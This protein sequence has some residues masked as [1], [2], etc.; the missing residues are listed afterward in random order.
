[1]NSGVF[2][3]DVK[4]FM[5]PVRWWLIGILLLLPFQ[6]RAADFFAQWNTAISALMRYLDEITVALFFPLALALLYK[7]RANQR[8]L[9][10]IMTAII[11]VG[12]SGIISG[13]IN[14]NPLFITTLGIFDYIKNFLVIVIYAVFFRD[15]EDFKSVFQMVLAVALF[16]GAVAFLQELWALSS[17]YILGKDIFDMSIYILRP[18]E[19]KMW[20]LDF[21]R[22]GL[23]RAP[24]LTIHPNNFGLYCLLILTIY[25]FTTKK[26]NPLIFSALFT[27]IFFSVS[28]MI[29]ISFV[30]LAG[31]QLLKD[32]KWLA[33]PAILLIALLF[34]LS[35]LPDLRIREGV[36][37]EDVEDIYF[38]QYAK[39]KAVEVWKDHPFFGA[40][41]GKF[42]GV[43][44]I[45]YGS[46]LYEE[47]NFSEKWYKFMKPFRSFDQ[48]WPQALA[49]IGI[50]GTI[51]F[52]G[53]LASLFFVF[54]KV[55]KN[56]LGETKRFSAGI[57][58]AT[59]FIFIYSLGSG[60]NMTSFLFTYSAFAG[61]ILGMHENTSNK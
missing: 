58:A 9:Y 48:F 50:I 18:S 14:G 49:E 12:I 13:I 5:K 25:L 60:L 16:L 19:E 27:G 35:A 46:P 61:M 40:G 59:V 20:I 57:S 31:L 34:F 33:A 52:A 21:W 37:R 15:I 38:R 1:M 45:A 6:L 39:S 32:R 11:A 36:S 26:I 30:L 44:S 23:Y 56:S 2:S 22:L 42:G 10:I 17:R 8:P 28:R 24:S 51:A 7:E 3:G 43:V 29:Y 47:Y 54:F 41:P 53:L 4:T 55:M